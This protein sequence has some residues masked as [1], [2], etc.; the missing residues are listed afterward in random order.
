MRGPYLQT[1][2]PSSIL[3]RWRTDTATGSIVRYGTRLDNL[4][5]VADVPEPTTEHA[6]EVAGLAPG[7]RYFYSI[8]SADETL[9]TGADYFFRTHPTPGQARPTRI[10]AIGDSGTFA[11][12]VGRQLAVRDAFYQY[13]QSRPADVWLALGD[14]AYHYGSDADYQASFFNVYPTLLRNTALWST[15]GNH[16]TYS[17]PA[18]QRIPYLDI[19]SF[20]TRGE[21][22][23][24]P[25]GTEQYY[26]FDYANIHFVCLDSELSD[27]S[28]SGPMLTWLRA[29]LE[30]NTADWLIA[31]WH[32]PPYTRGSHNSDDMRDGWGN[33]VDMRVNAAQLLEAYGVDLV[34]GGH[35]HAYERSYLLDGHYGF[36]NTF[37]PSMLKDAGTG[38]PGETGPY[39]KPGKGPHAHQGAVYIVAG[40]SGW[41]TSQM[42]HHPAM[43]Y[44]ELQ[45][46]SLVIDVD[47]D[48]LDAKFLRS[49]GAIGDAFTILKGTA[50][51]TLRISRF[52][53]REGE[54]IVTWKSIAGETYR[55]ERTPSLVHPSWKPAS[56]SITATG[57][58]TVW[59]EPVPAGQ[60]K[61]FYRVVLLPR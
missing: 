3:L 22:G 52:A 56:D 27:R 11:T 38:R 60:G 7:T 61:N 49:T 13:A 5:H 16:E 53:I 10:W 44:D 35:S 37:L 39:L 58:T 32:S 57:A 59:K 4:T 9:A 12:G 28:L 40:T 43:C 18:G 50:P 29:D 21:A 1:S 51:E 54:A 2:T 46:G 45:A 14:N 6:V 25:S 15:I 47:G 55:I 26:S 42:G 23:G 19:F 20:P 31:F 34:L 17:V 24:V 33:M 30:A 41:V 8:G 36:S 48:R